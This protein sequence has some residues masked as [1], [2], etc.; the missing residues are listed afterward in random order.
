MPCLLS[1]QPSQSKY[2]S[3]GSVS[4]VV[5]PAS[6]TLLQL[7][8][9]CKVYLPSGRGLGCAACCQ[10]EL[11]LHI[12]L[13]LQYGALI[14]AECV[15]PCRFEQSGGNVHLEFERPTDSSGS[16]RAMPTNQ[17]LRLIIARGPSN[18]ISSLQGYHG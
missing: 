14:T 3:D 11:Q 15:L 4:V 8:L 2:C 18:D 10:Q 7:T 17:P 5:L 16:E 13:H 1:L 9:V 6:F 12:P